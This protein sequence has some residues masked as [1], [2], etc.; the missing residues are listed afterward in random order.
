MP[1]AV[2]YA[3]PVPTSQDEFYRIYYPYAIKFATKYCGIYPQNVEDVIQSIW[4]NLLKTD[5]LHQFDPDKEIE[6]DG[7][8]FAAR[9]EKFLASKLKLYCRHYFH[10]QLKSKARESLVGTSYMP[11]EDDENGDGWALNMVAFAEY[12]E[13]GEDVFDMLVGDDD[14]ALFEDLEERLL[15]ERLTKYLEGVPGRFKSVDLVRLFECV[16]SQARL[17]DKA[18]V[19]QLAKI[20]KVSPA[21]IRT[22]LE[23]LGEHVKDALAGKEP[24]VIAQ[25]SFGGV[26][27]NEGQLRHALVLLVE[28]KSNMIKQPLAKASNVLAS[29]DYHAVCRDYRAEHPNF[30]P[31]AH[32][33]AEKEAFVAALEQAIKDHE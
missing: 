27:A 30:I 4:V 25:Q 3:N 15:V 11:D 13:R 2:R 33:H 14:V 21:I 6:H 29:C 18:N 19:S 23:V 9:F 1:T 7:V 24:P 17:E 32:R 8:K 26:T 28:C 12:A 10:Q 20:F 5:A 31:T 16:A 22:R